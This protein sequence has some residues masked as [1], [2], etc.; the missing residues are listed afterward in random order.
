MKYV[1]IDQLINTDVLDRALCGDCPL[2]DVCPLEKQPD[3]DF[4]KDF[5]SFFCAVR[6]KHCSEE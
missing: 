2:E 3:Y 4:E 6:K 5:N 1:D